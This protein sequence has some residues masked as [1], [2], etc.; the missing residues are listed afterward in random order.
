MSDRGPILACLDNLPIELPEQI[1]SLLSRK[2]TKALC[3]TNRTLHF[4]ASTKM[5]ETLTVSTHQESFVQLLSVAGSDLWSNQVRHVDWVLL[6]SSDHGPDTMQRIRFKDISSFGSWTASLKPF[7]GI[8]GNPTFYGLDLQCQLM[9]RIP[10]IQSIR[11]WSATYTQRTG[12][13][14]FERFRGKSRFIKR[15]E[16]TLPTAGLDPSADSIFSI[17]RHSDLKPRRIDT[18]SATIYLKYVLNGDCERIVILPTV[19][20]RGR[21]LPE[22]YR[23]YV[24]TEELGFVT[25]ILDY[26]RSLTLVGIQGLKDLYTFSIGRP[27]G[28]LQKMIASIRNSK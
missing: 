1:L 20:D 27:E 17:L 12:T 16:F 18:I 8:N 2:E 19:L 21:S 28:E 13:E 25:D 15:S 3:F 26:Y 11:S 22:R 23:G 9:R 4:V 5:F 14:P 10:N 7:G 24:N 6:S